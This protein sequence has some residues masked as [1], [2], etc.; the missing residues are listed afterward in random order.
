MILDD[1]FYLL[2]IKAELPLFKRPSQKKSGGVGLI[3]PR[4]TKGVKKNPAYKPW[5]R[6]LIFALK[7]GWMWT[8]IEF[9]VHL[10][11][12]LMLTQIRTQSL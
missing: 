10:N 2:V 12:F 11:D 3:A 4:A 6:L 7:F 5:L 1:G 8:R 9:L